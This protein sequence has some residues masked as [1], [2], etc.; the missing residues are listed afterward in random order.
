MPAPRPTPAPHSPAGGTPE[1]D[2]PPDTAE[3]PAAAKDA[4]Q[5]W[6]Q[7]NDAYE[8]ATQAMFQE[9]MSP[10]EVQAFMDHMDQLRQR[11]VQLSRALIGRRD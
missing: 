4:L 7:W 9:G 6:L 11:A 1:E 8:R 10:S 3:L 2:D 5:C